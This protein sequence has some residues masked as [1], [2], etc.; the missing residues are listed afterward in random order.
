MQSY[1][2][3]ADVSYGRCVHEKQVRVG[4]RGKQSV[5]GECSVSRFTLTASNERL[6]ISDRC[7]MRAAPE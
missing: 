1:F 5:D 7:G 2:P 4:V 6:R 3:F